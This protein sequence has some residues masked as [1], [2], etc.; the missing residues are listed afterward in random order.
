MTRQSNASHM[1]AEMV[2]LAN[3]GVPVDTILVGTPFRIN[4]YIE[5]DFGIMQGGS[6]PLTFYSPDSITNITHY[7]V[8]GISPSGYSDQSITN[9][10]GWGGIWQLFEQWTGINWDGIN[11]DTVNWTGVSLSGWMPNGAPIHYLSFAFQIN[12]PGTFCVDSCSIPNTIPPGRYNWLWDDPSFTF[13]GPYCWSI[14]PENYPPVAVN[15]SANTMRDSLVIIDVLAND[16]DPDGLLDSSSVTIVNNPSSGNILNIDPMSGDVTYEPDMGFQG[17]DNFTYTVDNVA[18]VTSNAAVVTV[19]V[20]FS[21]SPPVT[22]DDSVSTREDTFVIIDVLANDSDLDNNIDSSMVTIVRLPFNGNIVDIDTSNGAVFYKPDSNFFGMDS[23]TYTVDDDSSATSNVATVTV[24]VILEN[25][26]PPLA[27]ND[28]V[29]TDENGPV[30]IDILSNDFDPDFDIDSSSVKIISGP[31]NGNITYIDSI[32]GNAFYE[33]DSGFHGVDIFTYTVDDDSTVSSNVA[34][35][36]VNVL[37]N[38]SISENEE[39]LTPSDFFLGQNYPNPFNP[40]TTIAYTVKNPGHVTI[41]LYDIF[42]RKIKTLVNQYQKAQV[43]SVKFDARDLASG[44]YYY[45]LQVG[46][47]YKETKK[48]ILI[49]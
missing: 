9:Y 33:P 39:F 12:E 17:T 48:M 36:L 1:Y 40:T 46:N 25:D 7:N 30:I 23:F 44:V 16:Y 2:T 35:V 26:D 28:T 41:E 29:F 18:G 6:L 32:N 10:N 22:V 13:G 21:N 47:E 8:G 34:L 11:A 4:L 5:N 43:Y 49:R 45:K 14:V 15:D 37:L 3:P 24:T 38:T 20:N 19:F 31:Y 42:G 27:V